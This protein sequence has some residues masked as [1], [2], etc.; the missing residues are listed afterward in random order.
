MN[1]IELNVIDH[2]H[3]F[4]DLAD[5]CVNHTD[6]IERFNIIWAVFVFLLCLRA[7]I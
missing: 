7:L 6:L 2:I 3:F 4:I 1:F 5:H